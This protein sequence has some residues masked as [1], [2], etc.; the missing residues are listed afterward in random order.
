MNE[1]VRDG[2]WF[3]FHPHQKD[4]LNGMESGY[5]VFGCGSERLIVLI[6]R[7]SFTPWLEGMNK[8]HLE[9]R[10]YWH[11]HIYIE[12]DTLALNRSKGFPKID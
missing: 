11:V 8:T 6:P 3:V 9:D 5:V 2:F 10:F 7:D 1:V 12:D 4:F